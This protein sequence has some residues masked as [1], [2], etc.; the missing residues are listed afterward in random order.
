MSDV[1]LRILEY[2]ETGKISASAYGASTPVTSM[3]DFDPIME[4]TFDKRLSCETVV[5]NKSLI[6]TSEIVTVLSVNP[7]LS[8]PNKAP[9]SPI[10]ANPTS[11]QHISEQSVKKV[12]FSINKIVIPEQVE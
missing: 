3:K 1:I 8:P 2:Q 6:D 4:I 11:P 7:P 5:S 9:L 10:K 12:L